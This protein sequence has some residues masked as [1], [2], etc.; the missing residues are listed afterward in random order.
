MLN[1]LKPHILP[2][3][4]LLAA[5]FAAYA[6]TL[7]HEFLITWDDQ[8]Y[9]TSNEA[10][11]GFTL[12]HLKTAFTTFYIG[13]YAP[14]QI[15]S[16]MVDHSLWGMR[17]AGFI[18]GN[19]VL[20][21][22]NGALYYFLV[23]RLGGRRLWAFIASSI[24]LFHP[25][26][27]ES[28]AWISQR[29][30]VLAMFFLLASFLWYLAY[31]DRQVE[32]GGAAIKGP[33]GGL[34]YAGSVAAFFCA[35]LAKTVAV[36][37]PPLLLL[38]DLCFLADEGRR[39]WRRR[40]IDKTPYILAAAA[41]AALAYK[42]QLPEMGGGRHGYYGGGPFATFC[43]MLPVFVRYVSMIL[44]PTGL[45]ALYVPSV[46]GG[47]DGEVAVAA[48]VL[49]AIGVGLVILFRRR[50]DLFFFGALFWVGLLPVS[51]IVPLVTL[52]NDRYLYFPMLGGAAL[53]AGLLVTALDG[54]ALPARRVMIGAL[55]IIILALPILSYQRA[56]VWQSSLTLWS[57]TIVK[58][59][60]SPLSN[61]SLGSAYQMSGRVD[62]AIPLYLRAI[63]L[64]PTDLDA[65]INLANLYL[66]R[67]NPDAALPWI[68][69][70]TQSHP[71][72]SGGY[73]ALGHYYFLTHNLPE[74]EAASLRAVQLDP[75]APLPLHYLGITYTLEGKI[76][77]ARQ[78][79]LRA[80]EVGGDSPQICFDLARAEATAGNGSAAISRLENALKLGYRDAGSIGDNPEFASLKRTPEFRQ[81]IAKYLPR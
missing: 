43:T 63:E 29:K 59:P 6:G 70:L 8:K 54:L 27:V 40:L 3:L 21:A 56:K 44:W 37:L 66:N 42:S 48:L 79:L 12:D 55:A 2:V 15:V 32:S 18:F 34:P 80:L 78:A 81:L 47:V 53:A 20:H 22:L 14:L 52:M 77:P 24:F 9:V 60:D 67:G 68:Q 57:D 51:Q 76:E 28:V 65:L 61:F 41:V 5:T 19:I 26:Q 62:E 73:L 10:V 71:N 16:Y 7:G 1:R 72:F 50:K 64:D 23:L 31:R 17:P 45:S 38:H 35:L 46:K 74:A 75:R 33:R 11:K 4:V 25:V 36:I 13:N 39:G 58:A 49:A 30:N 69:M